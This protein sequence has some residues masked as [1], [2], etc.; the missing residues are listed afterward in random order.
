MDISKSPQ[1][2]PKTVQTD[3]K[4]YRLK[5]KKLVFLILHWI[6]PLN[7]SMKCQANPR[8][9][10]FCHVIPTLRPRAAAMCAAVQPSLLAWFSRAAGRVRA[11]G[12]TV[13]S[14]WAGWQRRW[15]SVSTCP[16]RTA[17]WRAVQPSCREGKVSLRPRLQSY[18]N[19]EYVW[20]NL[21]HRYENDW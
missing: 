14:P 4:H 5:K 15:R 11:S 10:I 16:E 17:A 20:P 9:H 3:K 21:I 8:D 2:S 7:T 19:Y 6:I 1:L 12:V 18:R 13:E